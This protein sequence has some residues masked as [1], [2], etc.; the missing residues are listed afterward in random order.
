MSAWSAPNSRLWMCSTKGASRAWRFS[1]FARALAALR[2]SAC[3]STSAFFAFF[4]NFFSG[5]GSAGGAVDSSFFGL[6][7]FR[8]I[9]FVA[10]FYYGHIHAPLI[11][12]QGG[13]HTSS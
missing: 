12:S 2:A 8:G 1:V 9:W 5:F 11:H 3:K 4:F 6:D 7:F 13:S 10:S